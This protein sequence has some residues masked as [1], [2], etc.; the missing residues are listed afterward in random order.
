MQNIIE[1]NTVHGATD[2]ISFFVFFLHTGSVSVAATEKDLTE[3]SDAFVGIQLVPW[4]FEP[5]DSRGRL[6]L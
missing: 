1:T 6:L 2:F 5:E 3:S 4:R